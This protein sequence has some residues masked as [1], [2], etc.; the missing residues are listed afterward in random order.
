MF[1]RAVRNDAYWPAATMVAPWALKMPEP[2]LWTVTASCLAL[3][4]ASR[5]LRPKIKLVCRD[6]SSLSPDLI[7]QVV[8]DYAISPKFDRVANTSA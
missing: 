7:D 8:I 4:L 6:F 1:F 2:S 3:P 5:L